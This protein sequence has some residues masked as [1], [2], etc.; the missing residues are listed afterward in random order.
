[1]G[2]GAAIGGIAAGAGSVFA[3][4]QGDDG[5]YSQKRSSGY[6]EEQQQLIKKIAEQAQGRVGEGVE[7]YPK[8]TIPDLTPGQQ[9]AADIGGTFLDENIPLMQ[10]RAEDLMTPEEFDPEARQEM[11]RK[12]IMAPARQ[13]WEEETA[14]GIMEKYGS[15][16]ALSSSAMGQALAESSEDI[17]KRGMSELANLTFQ[18]YQQQKQRNLQRQQMGSSLLGQI[19]GTTGQAANLAG[20][21]RDIEEARRQED[22]ESW[23]YERAYNRPWLAQ[24][25]PIAL[26]S[27][28]MQTSY[29]SKPPSTGSQLARQLGPQAGRLAGTALGNSMSGGSTPNY[30]TQPGTAGYNP[31]AMSA[32]G[33]G[34]SSFN[35]GSYPAGFGPGTG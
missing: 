14:P 32:G 21:P 6:T 31:P 15:R 12:S 2:W 16:N 22:K 5:G 30:G 1:M 17:T 8:S 33:G 11:W 3:A 24:A 25:A 20:M 23:L 9:Q 18:D 35:Y 10:K 29:I 7:S 4:S 13:E 19:L 27:Q 34:S 26:G 28:P